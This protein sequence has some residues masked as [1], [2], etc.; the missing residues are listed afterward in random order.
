MRTEQ[1]W[2]NSSELLKAKCWI[3]KYL[4]SHWASARYMRLIAIVR[5]ALH[6]GAWDEGT[7]AM[8]N[9]EEF[10]QTICKSLCSSFSSF[11]FLFLPFLVLHPHDEAFPIVRD[12]ERNRPIGNTG[13]RVDQT[14]VCAGPYVFDH[15]GNFLKDRW[16]RS[17]RGAWLFQK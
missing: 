6:I 4:L 10:V 14:N 1:T 3:R 17:V 16:C 9:W 15:D 7:M 5:F 13:L 12:L 2:F 11:S 8:K